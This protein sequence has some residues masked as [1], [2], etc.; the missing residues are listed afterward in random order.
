L[1]KVKWIEF[2]EWFRLYR[3]SDKLT[4][5]E[6]FS[7]KFNIDVRVGLLYDYNDRSA[8]EKI[9]NEYIS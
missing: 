6:A 4:L 1:R 8:Y 5:G 9:C 2:V 3:G 7:K